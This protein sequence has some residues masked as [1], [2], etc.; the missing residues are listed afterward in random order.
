M[1]TSARTRSSSAAT[2]CPPP[3]E[4]VRHVSLAS[5]DDTDGM[6]E[7]VASATFKE[8]YD[9]R[10]CTLSVSV[11]EQITCL[12]P[13]AAQEMRLCR[14]CHREF[15]AWDDVTWRDEVASPLPR[16]KQAVVPAAASAPRRAH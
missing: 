12:T 6:T 11:L 7:M 4:R 5:V 13:A 16:R 15:G 9:C 14:A 2:A 1:S 3:P 8:E 10:Q